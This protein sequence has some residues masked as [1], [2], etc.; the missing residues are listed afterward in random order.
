V[1]YFEKLHNEIICPVVPELLCRELQPGTHPTVKGKSDYFFFSKLFLRISSCYPHT[2]QIIKSL[3]FQ[4]AILTSI[5][6]VDLFI[7]WLNRNNPPKVG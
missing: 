3:C 6:N 2:G 1:K 4:M 7:Q 5:Q